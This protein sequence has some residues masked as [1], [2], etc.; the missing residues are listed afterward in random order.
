MDANKKKIK[1]VT[2]CSEDRSMTHHHRTFSQLKKKNDK[3]PVKS[4]H[5]PGVPADDESGSALC[6]SSVTIS[7]RESC[8]WEKCPTW[9]HDKNSV[10]GEFS[11]LLSNQRQLW[12]DSRSRLSV[13]L[14]VKHTGWQIKQLCLHVSFTF[15]EFVRQFMNSYPLSQKCEMKGTLFFISSLLSKIEQKCCLFM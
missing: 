9:S 12:N 14:Q 5:H 2:F 4:R 13:C 8:R 15:C 7:T 6:S 1:K 11:K 3:R 10:G